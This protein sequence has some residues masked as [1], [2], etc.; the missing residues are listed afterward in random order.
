LRPDPVG[1]VWGAGHAAE[2]PYLW[3]SF[4]NGTPIAPTFDAGERGL[5][6]AMVQAWGRFVSDTAPSSRKLPNWPAFSDTHQLMSLNVDGQSKTHTEAA[7]TTAHQCGFW[8]PFNTDL[9]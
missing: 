9:S 7:F 6:Q 3:P 2:L 1:Y 4:D 5:S 8:D